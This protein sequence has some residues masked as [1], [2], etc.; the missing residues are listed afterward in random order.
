MHHV[1]RV[2]ER[3]SCTAHTVSRIF[4]EHP[5]DPFFIGTYTDVHHK[6]H[7]SALAE[8]ILFFDAREAPRTPV[9]L[10]LPVPPI[11]VPAGPIVV[12]SKVIGQMRKWGC[13]FDG[14]DPM[15]F[16][17]QIAELRDA[18]GFSDR[19][20]LRGLFE[21]LR[22]D[23]L[24]WLRN[25]REHWRTWDDFDRDFRGQFLL[26]RYQAALRREITDRRQ[27]PGETYATEM[28]TLMRRSGGFNRDKQVDRLYE[29]MSPDYK[30]YVR[31][32]DV[33]NVTE[34]QARAADYEE[35]EAQRREHAKTARKADDKPTVTAAYKKECCWRCKQRG[36]TRFNCKKSPR[37]FC[38]QCGRDGVLTKQC[39]PPPG[40]AERAGAATA[41]AAAPSPA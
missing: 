5:Q 8:E 1:S 26:R 18:Y 19:Q 6:C 32:D 10:S 39:H 25:N 27:R 15:A 38:S 12:D 16:L 23:P 7:L 3:T 30:F 24:L 21:L 9:T 2:T 13:H 29:N 34:L 33:T 36:H 4:F 37:K 22:G 31:Y 14:K 17:E 35:I 41:N 20:L 28:L 11:Q 40:N